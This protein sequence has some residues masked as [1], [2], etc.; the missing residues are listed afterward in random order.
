M[1][2]TLLQLDTARLE[3]SMWLPSEMLRACG[4]Q[5]SNGFVLHKLER[6][7]Q[8]A[9]LLQHFASHGLSDVGEQSLLNRYDTKYLLP[10]RHLPEYLTRL[11][12]HYSVL[13]IDGRQ[14]HGYR[15]LYL[16]TPAFD[17]YLDHHNRRA[18][19]S[20]VRLRNYVG[21]DRH[22]LELKCK[23]NK[24][25]TEK[26]RVP[27]AGDCSDTQA[28]QLL[29]GPPFAGAVKATALQ[30]KVCIDYLRISL[31][32]RHSGERVTIDIGFS[33]TRCDN[34]EAASL[35]ALAIV[36]LKRATQHDHSMAW[37]AL[38]G[39]GERPT[40]ISKYCMACALLFPHE[41]KRNRFKRLL[42][43]LAPFLQQS[44]AGPIHD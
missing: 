8:L 35:D 1:T 39:F 33:A 2:T 21:T 3:R 5:V 11:H 6:P 37:Q 25:R 28:L 34:G 17:S 32:D 41:L 14:V 12:D 20:K 27:V 10:V 38:R 44:P 4:A 26:R 40:A 29:Q 42:L 31:W 13:E 15:T 30:R 23:T 19:R 7:Q 16:D 24:Q 22:F 18:R 9:L 43:R 36:E